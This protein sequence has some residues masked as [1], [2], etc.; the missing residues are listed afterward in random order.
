MITQ[1][2]NNSI[3]ITKNFLEVKEKRSGLTIVKNKQ[4]QII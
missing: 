3:P 2:N 1:M 4:K